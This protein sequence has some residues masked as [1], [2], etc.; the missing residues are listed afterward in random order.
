M[1]LGVAGLNFAI[2]RA[3]VTNDLR[4]APS[5]VWFIYEP[6]KFSD[7]PYNS[8]FDHTSMLISVNNAGYKCHVLI[9]VESVS[10]NN[11]GIWVSYQSQIWKK[12]L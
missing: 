3:T 7:S 1:N 12:I 6:S 2:L 9:D 11:Q 8:G 5:G 10:T 4:T